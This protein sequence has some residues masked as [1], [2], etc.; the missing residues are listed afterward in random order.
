MF[1]VVVG[2]VAAVVVVIAA[3]ELV[4]LGAG[5][6]VCSRPGVVEYPVVICDEPNG[7]I[8]EPVDSGNRL[9]A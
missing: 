4:V 3:T 8:D 7:F 1:E 9:V 2:V 6:V 5:F